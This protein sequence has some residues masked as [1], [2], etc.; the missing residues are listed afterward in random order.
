MIF[1]SRNFF[2]PRARNIKNI[3]QKINS[4]KNYFFKNLNFLKAVSYI[5][6]STKMRFPGN[7][8]EMLKLHYHITSSKMVVRGWY[9]THFDRRDLL[10]SKKQVWGG[11]RN[12]PDLCGPI[13]E[14]SRFFS[15]IS[16]CAADRKI[17]IFLTFES[18]KNVQKLCFSII[19][20]FPQNYDTLA[21]FWYIYIGRTPNRSKV[22]SF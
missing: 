5:H 15:K 17:S 12:L 1:I 2:F 3:S 20:N 22:L 9:M 14:F 13:C 21:P 16:S 10:N 8:P 7:R 19:F 18:E 6:K 4:R 11:F